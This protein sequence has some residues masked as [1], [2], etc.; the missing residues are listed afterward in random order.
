MESAKVALRWVLQKSDGLVLVY[1]LYV[2]MR[3]WRMAHVLARNYKRQI[4]PF[5]SEQWTT[6]TQS[7]TKEL[8][9]GP[10]VLSV[11]KLSERQQLNQT[12]D[13]GQTQ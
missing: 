4:S 10:M 11:F 3:G 8:V 13:S 5:N 9:S 2:A 1:K 12:Q 6:L 7:S